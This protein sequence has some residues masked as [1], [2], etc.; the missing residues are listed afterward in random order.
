MLKQGNMA[1]DPKMIFD[2][3]N[4]EITFG[5]LIADGA[6]RFAEE[7]YQHIQPPP[8]RHAQLHTLT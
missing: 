8:V 7:V 1:T 6:E 5:K 2:V 4:R 3:G